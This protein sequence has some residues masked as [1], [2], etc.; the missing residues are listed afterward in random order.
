MG[1]RGGGGAMVSICMQGRLA[2][3]CRTPSPQSLLMREAI[4]LMRGTLCLPMSLNR[5][6]RRRRRDCVHHQRD[7][8]H[9]APQPSSHCHHRHHS[10]QCCFRWRRPIASSC[11]PCRYPIGPW[12][13]HGCTRESSE[14]IR[15]HQRSSE[16][17]RGH[18]RPSEVIRGHQ[19]PSEFIRG[20]QSSSL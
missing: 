10:R 1:K 15:G 3:P 2:R 7:R 17:I 4:R 11:A 13:S 16:V 20:H 12:R 8:R 9:C 5:R 18:Q 14:V 19:R 6:R